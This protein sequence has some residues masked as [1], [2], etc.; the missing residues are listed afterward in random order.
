MVYLDYAANCPVD[1]KVLEDFNLNNILYYAN[2]NSSHKLGLEV[3]Q[4]IDEVSKYISDI[5]KCDMKDIIYTSG[6]TESNNLAIKGFASLNKNCHIITTEIEHS[7]IIA[8]C[9]Y[10]LSKGYKVDILPV[11]NNGQIDINKL[12]E[13]IGNEETLVSITTVE[14]ETGIVENIEEISNILKKYDNVV[15]HTDATQS[16]GK[17]NFNFENV[18]MITFTPHKFYGISGIGVLIKK[19]NVKLLP[20]IHG[21][22]STT[23][24]RSGTPMTAL[25]LSVKK[26]LELAITNM[27]KNNKYIKEINYYLKQ[28]L[29]KY[30]NVYFNSTDNSIYN[31]LNISIK[32][33]DSNLFSKELEKYDIY[34]STKSACSSDKNISK[35]IYAITHDEERSKSSLRISL[36]HLTTKDEIDEFLN[37]FDIIYKS[38]VK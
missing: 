20:L 33:V 10:L 6:S 26:S 14:S 18:D 11:N 31:T 27:D 36:S 37:A 17:L 1:K 22:K 30:S 35:T 12:E 8:P 9:N 21:G 2:P 28:N 19:D 29:S 15:F 38:L 24:Y 5:F 25:I 32:G 16:I 23:K 13:L 7:S 34:I 3:K 4:K